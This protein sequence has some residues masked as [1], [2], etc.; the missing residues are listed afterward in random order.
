[1]TSTLQSFTS[2]VSLCWWVANSSE[3]NELVYSMRSALASLPGLVRNFHLVLYDFPFDAS[4]DKTLLPEST[5]LEL[6]LDSPHST[7]GD[8][9]VAQT[10]AWL[11]F[12][13]LTTLPHQD[14]AAAPPR[15][16]Y[17]VHSELFHLPSGDRH[18]N[19]E[20]AK[21]HAAREKAWREKALPTYSSKSIE[22]RFGWLPDLADVFVAMNDDFFLLKRHA[23]STACVTPAHVRYLTSIRPCTGVSSGLIME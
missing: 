17:A 23:V 7:G 3:L 6:G 8:L 19:A 9:R 10:P 11:N 15:L 4:R 14:G 20:Y 16:R 12:S 13:S 18:G 22:T 21:A 5:R 2:G 1:M